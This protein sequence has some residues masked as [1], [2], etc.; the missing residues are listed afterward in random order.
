MIFRPI[1]YADTDL[2][3]AISGWEFARVGLVNCDI[4][5]GMDTAAFVH[6]DRPDRLRVPPMKL[7][8]KHAPY[9]YP[10]PKGVTIP[11]KVWDSDNGS[12]VDKE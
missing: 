10:K 7:P 2:C 6:N 12:W 8:K 3:L 4:P 11:G 5:E 1:D 9:Q